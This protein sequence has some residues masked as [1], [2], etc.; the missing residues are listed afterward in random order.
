MLYIKIKDIFFFY[1]LRIFLK[2][3]IPNFKLYL[4]KI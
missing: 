3:F 2:N 1:K 4:D